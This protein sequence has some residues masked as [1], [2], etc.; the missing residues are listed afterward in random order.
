M[1]EAA[2]I[3]PLHCSDALEVGYLTCRS[4]S[5]RF[6]P[7][8]NAIPNAIPGGRQGACGGARQ[9]TGGGGPSGGAG[10]IGPI[11]KGIHA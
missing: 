10:S 8:P 7:H 3:L 11:N 9:G 6:R 1:I 4:G 2:E 5:L